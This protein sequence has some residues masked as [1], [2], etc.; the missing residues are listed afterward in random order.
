MHLCALFAPVLLALVSSVVV[1]APALVGRTVPVEP[2]E[3]YTPVIFF[4]CVS[5]VFIIFFFFFQVKGSDNFPRAL[6]FAR[7]TLLPT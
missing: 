4:V 2:Q 1:A 6:H 5:F 3:R 7:M